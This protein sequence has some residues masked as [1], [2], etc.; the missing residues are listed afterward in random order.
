MQST[1]LVLSEGERA[2]MCPW[3]LFIHGVLA[4][5][6]LGTEWGWWVELEINK[7]THG[8]NPGKASLVAQWWRIACQC[9]RHRRHGFNPRVGKIPCRRKWQPPPV[10][11]SGKSHGQ[12][13]LVGYSPWGRKESDRTERLSTSTRPWKLQGL[14]RVLGLS[15]PGCEPGS[16]RNCP[17]PVAMDAKVFAPMRSIQQA[18]FKVTVMG[19]VNERGVRHSRFVLR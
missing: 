13:S 1:D 17:V 15:G 8:V 11:L 19:C 6:I 5:H 4:F 12:R 16:E 3:D 2:I 10:F 9:G 18:R 7:I 14:T